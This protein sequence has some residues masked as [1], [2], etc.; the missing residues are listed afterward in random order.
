[1]KRNILL[2]ALIVTVMSPVAFA[3]LILF[4]PVVVG[5][6]GFGN[7]PR[8]LTIQSH[9][10]SQ[11]SE[12]GCIAP[13]GGG[14][15]IAGSGACAPLDGVT[16]GDEQ[17]PIGFPKQSAPTLSSLGITNA[18]QI[19]ILLDGVQPQNANNN[20]VTINDLTL[21]LYSG[22]TLVFTASGTFS[23]L[24]TNPGN[25][26]TDYLFLLNSTEAAEFNA[27]VAGH[28]ED[29]IALDSTISFPRQS[30]GPDSY[31]LVNT[32][33]LSGVSIEAVPEPAI[34]VM[35]GSGLLGLGLFGRKKL[36]SSRRES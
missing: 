7:L 14:G 13:D 20:V 6:A 31:A 23:N 19:G 11:N 4:G 18:N 16:G 24:A 22:S 9:G 32:T 36:S 1:M 35:I 34:A 2:A 15:L 8:A 29:R 3:D 5:G 30:A 27:A 25:G 12:S 28:F 17:N 21:K 26:K 33:T 10:P